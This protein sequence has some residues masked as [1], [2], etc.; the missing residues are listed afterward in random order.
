MEQLKCFIFLYIKKQKTNVNTLCQRRLVYV[1]ILW[2]IVCFLSQKSNKWQVNYM[3]EG[4]PILASEGAFFPR[5]NCGLSIQLFCCLISSTGAL[6]IFS[7]TKKYLPWLLQIRIIPHKN[8]IQ[9]RPNKIHP[10]FSLFMFI[11]QYF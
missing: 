3:Q 7:H 1:G 8:L 6:K 11:N 9:N 5:G 2:P 10:L 4:I